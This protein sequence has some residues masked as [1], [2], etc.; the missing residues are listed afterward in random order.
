[1]KAME[2]AI[3]KILEA[4]EEIPLRSSHQHSGGESVQLDELSSDCFSVSALINY[5]KIIAT[6]PSNLSQ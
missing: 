4:G 5:N 3:S 6:N 1:M 2:A